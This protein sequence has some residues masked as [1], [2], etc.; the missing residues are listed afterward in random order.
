MNNDGFSQYLK[1]NNY[2]AKEGPYTHLLMNGGKLKV[3]DEDIENFIMK[4]SQYSQMQKVYVIELKTNIFSFFLD[5]DFFQE[6]GLPSHILLKY[7]TTIQKSIY[8][9]LNNTHDPKETRTIVC[10]TK[11]KSIVKN[12]ESYI[13]T[14]V[15]LYWPNIYVNKEYSLILRNIIIDALI[16]QYGERGSHNTWEDV[17]DK[18]VLE[19]NGLRMVGS[20]KLSNCNHCKTQKVKNEECVICHGFGRIDEGRIYEPMWIIDGKGK[21]LKSELSKVLTNQHKKIKETSIRTTFTDMPKMFKVP[22]QYLLQHLIVKKRKNMRKMNN[23]QEN[24]L[25][26]IECTNKE[27]L[28]KDSK[29]FKETA[30]FIRNVFPHPKRIDIIEIFKKGVDKNYYIVRTSS[31]F[32]LNI[33]REH[34]SNH[35]YYYINKSFAYQKCLCSCDTTVG[36]INGKCMDYK[37]S[38]RRVPPELQKILFPQEQNKM[39]VLFDIPKFNKH[40]SKV[41]KTKYLEGLQAYAD[42]LE[43]DLCKREQVENMQIIK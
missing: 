31:R 28:E 22:D 19:S 37:S 6:I 43:D 40:D 16:D 10:I 32:C 4:Y 15:H 41:N 36:R 29:A 9:I 8:N 33:N 17:V 21:E 14:G 7:I 25:F 13:K 23:N 20:R 34:R 27:C 5:L 35:I 2:Y 12:N 26:S 11:D 24:S 1:M 3:P 30:K 42:Y 18:T 39:A 38:G